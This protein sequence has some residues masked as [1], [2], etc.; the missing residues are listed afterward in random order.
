MAQNIIEKDGEL[1]LTLRGEALLAA[2]EAHLL[3]RN[4]LGDGYDIF[5]FNTFW[6][7]LT[8]DIMPRYRDEVEALLQKQPGKQTEAES[9]EKGH[10]QP[11]P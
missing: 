8:L 2:Q 1:R 11:Q 9:A 6:N 3:R 4:R 5:D 7:W 10:E